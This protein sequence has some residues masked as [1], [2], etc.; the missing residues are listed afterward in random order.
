VASFYNASDRP[1]YSDFS[2]NED[3]FTSFLYEKLSENFIS[4][5]PIL[6][7]GK[8]YHAD[9]R[10]A[11]HV[12][13]DAQNTRHWEQLGRFFDKYNVKISQIIF[14]SIVSPEFMMMHKPRIFDVYMNLLKSEGRIV[15]PYFSCWSK[16][17]ASMHCAF[18]RDLFS[19]KIQ[20][21]SDFVIDGFLGALFSSP[22]TGL[23]Y[24]SH[25]SK[26]PLFSYYAAF[27]KITQEWEKIRSTNIGDA[28]E[29]LR[30]E[31]LLRINEKCGDVRDALR[32]FILDTG[33]YYVSIFDMAALKSKEKLS[34]R[35]NFF[36]DTQEQ[37]MRYL[38]PLYKKFYASFGYDI[39]FVTNTRVAKVLGIFD[40]VE[41]QKWQK[42]DY[43]L[44]ERNHIALII[45]KNE[46]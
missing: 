32:D 5:D 16:E 45:K 17:C 9:Q 24:E 27:L 25:A 2:E 35:R 4:I 8:G 26:T 34:S 38:F 31:L 15:N 39:A 10:G 41:A 29:W 1:N 36:K 28:N 19:P 14:T 43:P 12:I 42:G 6:G 30:R 18:K 22:H 46:K 11:G 13:M 21:Q 20:N 33:M 37:Q 7:I 40:V 23:F 3:I 44:G